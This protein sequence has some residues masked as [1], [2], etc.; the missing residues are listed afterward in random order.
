MDDLQQQGS[1]RSGQLPQRDLLQCDVLVLG[2]GPAGIAA[3]CISA[4]CSSR[5]VLLES[6]PWLGG[7][8]WRANDVRSIPRSGQH[9]LSRLKHSGAQVICEATAFAQEGGELCSESGAVRRVYAQRCDQLLE[10]RCGRLVIATGAQELFL[11]FPGWTLPNVMGLG[12]LQLLAKG[13]WP[14][15]GQRVI[16]AGTGPLLFAVAAALKNRGAQVTDLLEQASWSRVA[17][18][19]AVLPW[20]SPSKVWQALQLKAQLLGARYRTGC[21]PAAA[22]GDAVLRSVRITDGRRA[23]VQDCDYLACG[24]GLV[25]NLQWPEMLGCTAHGDEVVQVDEL[26]Q[27]VVPGVYA[28][29]ETTGIGGDAAAVIEGQIAGHAASGC[30]TGR[31]LRRLQVRRARAGRFARSLQAAFRLRP[32][33]LMLAHDDTVICRCEDVTWGQLREFRDAR[34]AKLQTRCGMGVC[35]G[36]VCQNSLRLLKS[37]PTTSVRPPVLPVLAGMWSRIVR[38]HDMDHQR[39]PGDQS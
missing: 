36:R 37:W 3:A 9:W 25:P 16:V 28:A 19:A 14:V 27:T 22:H 10:V 29:G 4:E 11:P 13:G 24:F 8:I 26:Q 34:E 30:T 12:G 20:L 39:D 6:T 15:R 17:R 2:G 23:W 5:V 21:W 18:F 33:L 7:A 32:E 31:Q 35:Q 38:E 1:F